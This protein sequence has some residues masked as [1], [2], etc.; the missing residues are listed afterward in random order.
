MCGAG[1]GATKVYLQSAARLVFIIPIEHQAF[2]GVA[3][4]NNAVGKVVEVSFKS[5]GSN[6]LPIVFQKCRKVVD[7]RCCK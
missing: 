3:R 2:D 6:V 7:G 1:C 5:A 4:R